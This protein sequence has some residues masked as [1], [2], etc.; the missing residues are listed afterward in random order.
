MGLFLPRRKNCVFFTTKN[1]AA[2]TSKINTKKVNA[3]NK[4]IKTKQTEFFT[5]EQSSF[6][7]SFSFGNASVIVKSENYFFFCL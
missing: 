3:T 1:D 7:F 2:E 4:I 6:D 5:W